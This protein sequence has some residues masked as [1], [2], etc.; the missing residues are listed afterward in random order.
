MTV[1]MTKKYPRRK[2]SIAK[3]EP[4][5]AATLSKSRTQ[6]DPLQSYIS[7]VRNINHPVTTAET[8]A[9]PQAVVSVQLH[10]HT[11]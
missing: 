5:F 6:I 11:H 1:E 10:A 3:N 9:C 7:M 2:K 8:H 4:S